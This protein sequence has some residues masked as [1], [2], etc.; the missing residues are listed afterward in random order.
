[1]RAVALSLLI[2]TSAAAQ[3][4]PTASDPAKPADFSVMLIELTGRS[5]Y[6]GV[7]LIC[8]GDSE[9]SKPGD[10]CMSAVYDVPID[11][12]RWIAGPRTIHGRRLRYKIIE[13][14]FPEGMT[15][16]AAVVRTQDAPGLYAPWWKMPDERGDIC[17]SREDAESLKIV[18]QWSRWKSRL[19]GEHYPVRCLGT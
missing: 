7:P 16:L 1:V 19:L 9:P 10:I 2:A 3:S 12:V 13:S 5:E 6:K 17:L 11:V 15:I 14:G 18:S 8:P 4:T